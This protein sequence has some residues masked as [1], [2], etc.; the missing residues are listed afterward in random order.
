[1]T[2]ASTAARL[3]HAYGRDIRL[4]L[5]LFRQHCGIANPVKACWS[6]QLQRTGFLDAE[7]SLA[8]AVHGA[9]C[10]VE[11][12]AGTLVSFDLDERDQYRF[13]PWKFKLYADS[14]AVEEM[15]DEELRQLA[16]KYFF[17]E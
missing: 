1:M 4:V 9:G 11:F 13:D 3:L 17:S 7:Q 15:A 2:S 5:Q 6:Q 12:P 14:P 8:Y 10:T 16:E